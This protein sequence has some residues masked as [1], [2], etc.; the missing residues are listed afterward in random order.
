MSLEEILGEWEL[1]K[2]T[3]R[4]PNLD[5]FQKCLDGIQEYKDVIES[6]EYPKQ[7]FCMSLILQN[8]KLINEL[9]IKS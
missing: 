7:A 2:I 1:F 4:K 8:Q 5:Y 6:H 9:I 3:L